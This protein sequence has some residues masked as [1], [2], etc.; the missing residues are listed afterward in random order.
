MTPA[1]NNGLSFRKFKTAD[2]SLSSER[3]RRRGPG[4][5]SAQNLLP[6]P[7]P[8]GRIFGNESFRALNSELASASS[9]ALRAPSPPIRN[10]GEGRGEEAPGFRG[11]IL[12][13]KS[14]SRIESLNFGTRTER[15]SMTCSSEI[16]HERNR[17]TGSC[18]LA[19][20]LRVTDSRSDNEGSGARELKIV[21][22]Q[23][24]P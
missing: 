12:R 10:G 1:P 14:F 22:G 19:T 21:R 15:R 23:V 11:R 5:F 6:N 20:L 2:D 7:P 8:R 4:W 9:P 16:F 18:R 17:K 3:S 13:N 24:A